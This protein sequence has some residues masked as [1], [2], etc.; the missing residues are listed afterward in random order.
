MTEIDFE[1]LQFARDFADDRGIRFRSDEKIKSKISE[2]SEFKRQ[3]IEVV[4]CYNGGDGV[5]KPKLNYVREI[6]DARRTID[7][8]TISDGSY[9]FEA[10]NSYLDSVN[11][12]FRF[13]FSSQHA[14]NIFDAL[15][16]DRTDHI[17]NG[18]KEHEQV[19]F[20]G[21]PG[22]DFP[23]LD[24]GKSYMLKTLEMLFPRGEK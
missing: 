21:Y 5:K 9:Y 24:L 23:N 10:Q 22:C 17:F 2:S 16:T 12:K 11:L 14:Q 20:Y 15:R 3:G 6:W 8:L 13:H 19:G 1:L 7:G 18:E 4:S